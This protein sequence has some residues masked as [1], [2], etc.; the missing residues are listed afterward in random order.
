MIDNQDL[1]QTLIAL[2]ERIESATP[3]DR[4]AHPAV[5]KARNL[6]KTQLVPNLD[7][8]Q[9]TFLVPLTTAEIGAIAGFFS[10]DQDIDTQL[11]LLPDWEATRAKFP[12]RAFWEVVE[13]YG[14][15]FYAYSEGG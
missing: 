1:M 5:T 14:D 15:D 11:I 7:P 13:M 2:C 6:I 12:D 8:S 10:T 3:M 9:D 4:P